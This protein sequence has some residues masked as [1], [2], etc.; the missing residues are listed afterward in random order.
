MFE[1]F[2]ADATDA[3]I[4]EYFHGGS[5]LPGLCQRH[6]YIKEFAY[7]SDLPLSF[8]NKTESYKVETE[9]N[10]YYKSFYI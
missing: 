9:K 2:C 10:V 3:I 8:E 7:L 1:H 5:R 4:Y 6:T